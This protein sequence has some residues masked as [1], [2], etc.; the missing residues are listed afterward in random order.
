MLQAVPAQRVAPSATYSTLTEQLHTCLSRA[1]AATPPMAPVAGLY[2]PFL[3]SQA[4][5]APH[6]VGL[7]EVLGADSLRPALSPPEVAPPGRAWQSEALRNALE[8]RIHPAFVARPRLRGAFRQGGH[9]GLSSEA[10][11]TSHCMVSTVA[12]CV[13]AEMRRALPATY[14]ASRPLEAVA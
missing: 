11:N 1:L 10:G 8:R 4:G 12:T 3:R 13:T 9:C 2:R 14:A 6:R 5:S 7:G